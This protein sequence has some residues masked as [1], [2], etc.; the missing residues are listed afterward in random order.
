MRSVHFN[1]AHSRDLAMI[2]VART[3]PVGID[4]E[5]ADTKP[6]EPEA[7]GLVLSE[8]ENRLIEDG[9]DFLRVWVRKEAYAKAL[10]SGL[11]R[12]LA[13]L[14]LTPQQEPSSEGGIRVSDIS[15][16]DALAAVAAP[17]RLSTTFLGWWED[18]GG[19]TG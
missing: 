17:S 11:E 6:L 16:K 8:A 14:T 2:A 3:G 13:G 12:N 9:E 18:D 15:M 4:V 10:G 1:L 5:L 19:R 7:A